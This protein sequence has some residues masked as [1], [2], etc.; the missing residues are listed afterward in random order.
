MR[1]LFGVWAAKEVDSNIRYYLDRG[2]VVH[3]IVNVSPGVI[4]VYLE[5]AP[6]E[7]RE[8]ES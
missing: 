1:T 8:I 7:A 2:Y 4:G 3:T 6:V 5:T